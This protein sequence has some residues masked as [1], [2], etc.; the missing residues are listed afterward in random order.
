M[1]TLNRAWRDLLQKIDTHGVECAPRGEP[2]LELLNQTIQIDM[3][4]PVLTLA[5]RKLNYLFMLDEARWIISGSDR[6][7]DLPSM[8]KMMKFCSDDG[9]R[10]AG[11]YGPRFIGQID[12]LVAKLIVD[13]DTR[14]ATM[15]I[16]T[17][18]PEPSKDIPCTVAI[19]FMI[20]N[21][22][23]HTQV[24]MRSSDVWLGLPYDA[25]SF[26]MMTCK[27]LDYVNRARTL[28]K[29]PLHGLGHLYVTAASSH[30]YQ[31]DREAAQRC[32]FAHDGSESDGG[33]L[34]AHY[35]DRTMRNDRRWTPMLYLEEVIAHPAA[36][37]WKVA[38]L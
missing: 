8:P 22:F 16:W 32:L 21:G 35:Y 30:L 18:N 19:S 2:V 29:L 34:P 14:Q 24:F 10:M 38:E 11:A 12:S 33:A 9:V 6:V 1:M 13:P 3:R 17:P 4:H 20:R 26:T 27:V 15:T 37:W 7:A 28:D 5:A 31:R 23:I 36:R 25:F